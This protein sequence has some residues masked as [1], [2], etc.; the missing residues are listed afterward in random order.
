MNIKYIKDLRNIIMMKKLNI[1][2]GGPLNTKDLKRDNL[3]EYKLK[4]ISLL[5]EDSG[6]I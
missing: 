2:A 1:K 4:V 6:E 3:D 5:F